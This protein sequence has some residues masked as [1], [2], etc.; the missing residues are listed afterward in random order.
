VLSVHGT[1]H[2][3]GGDVEVISEEVCILQVEDGVEVA[4]LFAHGFVT[5]KASPVV[6][7]VLLVDDNFLPGMAT[8]K[9]DCPF[10]LDESVREFFLCSFQDLEPC[11][12][13]SLFLMELTTFIVW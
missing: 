13:K 9:F 12:K 3:W 10:D 6:E 7:L 4:V 11:R 2:L 5:C 1:H 8:W